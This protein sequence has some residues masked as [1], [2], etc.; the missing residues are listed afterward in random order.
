MSRSSDKII[1][2]INSYLDVMKDTGRM[3]NVITL[4]KRQFE[5]LKIGLG[6]TKEKDWKPRFRSIPIEI[7]K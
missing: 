3:P 2:H 6:K 7:L 4:T 5:D 1:S